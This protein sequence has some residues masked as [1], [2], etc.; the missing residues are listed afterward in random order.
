M[1]PN[2][3]AVIIILHSLTANL[4]D[5]K[6]QFP[7]SQC[8]IFALLSRIIHRQNKKDKHYFIQ[9]KLLF[10]KK[11]KSK[12][13]SWPYQHYFEKWNLFHLQVTVWCLQSF[14]CSDLFISFKLNCSNFCGFF[15]YFTHLPTRYLYCLHTDVKKK[16]CLIK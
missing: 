6:F 11:Y 13:K 7:G 2:K 1:V 9:L 15:S 16:Y 4:L 10:L 12:P 3:F 8:V 5:H 14:E